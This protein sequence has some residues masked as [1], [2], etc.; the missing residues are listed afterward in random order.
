MQLQ[1]VAHRIPAD[2]S[3]T[4]VPLKTIETFDI[5]I[6]CKIA[7][8]KIANGV[9]TVVEEAVTERVIMSLTVDW[10]QLAAVAG[11]RVKRNARGKAKLCLGAITAKIERS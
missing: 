10:V 1:I 4:P 8:V 3:Q 5:D 6:P 11:Q 7:T 9:E 2:V